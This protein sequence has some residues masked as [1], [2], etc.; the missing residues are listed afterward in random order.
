MAIPYEHAGERGEYIDSYYSRTLDVENEFPELTDQITA[1]VCIIG[2]GMAG[3]ATA[4]GLVERG[5]KPVLIEGNRIGWG[6]SGRN[7]SFCSAGYSL[8]ADKIVKKVGKQHAK[9]LL[10]LTTEALALIKKRIGDRKE[11]RGETDGLLNVSW[12][13]ERAAVEKNIE[14]MND[15]MGVD[16]KFW[17]REQIRGLY[18][19]KRYYDGYLKGCGIQVH[20][21][22]YNCHA[23]KQAEDG[24]ARIFE[25][26]PAVNITKHGNGW[27]VTTEKGSI[28]ADQIVM[29]CSAYIGNLN[30]RLSTATLPVATYVLLTEPLG[31]R[32]KSA[33]EGPY[34]VS[35]NRFS[36]N[37]YRTLPDS[38][39][40]WG[41]RV[42]MFNPSGEKLKK[43]MMDDLLVVYPQL[44]GIKADVAWG[45][46]MGYP[47]HKMPQIGELEPGFWYA[48]GFGGSGM[49]ATV[50]GGEVV[51]AAI[52]NG[53][54][55]YKLFEPYG[56]DYAGKPF[57]PIVAQ[58]AYWL[59]QLQDAY[60][61]WR[62][63]K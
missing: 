6:A 26:S 34:G 8:G 24:G 2:G 63:N 29:C 4:Q 43:I 10:S 39:L 58:T 60:K 37:Y 7:G 11:L 40:F 49:T 61:A 45:G 5:I 27:K 51:S 32:L 35:D 19:S 21:L 53:D 42:S 17:S 44:R 55:R 38:R 23:A 59:F 50:A 54:E 52:A 12:F 14:F 41:G 20:S 56:L 9:E 33:V 57:G 25:K 18:H 48:Q 13:D 3:V 47:A 15:V 1:P 36:S 22:N 16:Y 28:I 62:L 31:E 30:F 46:L